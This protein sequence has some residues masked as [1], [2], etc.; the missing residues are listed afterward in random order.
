MDEWEPGPP[1][2]ASRSPSQTGTALESEETLARDGFR[3]DDEW[4]SQK[5][6]GES[7]SFLQVPLGC[8]PSPAGWS[9]PAANGIQT[10]LTLQEASSTGDLRLVDGTS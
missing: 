9:P 4:V 5:D 3:R 10:N 6:T 7:R 1:I 8:L 2:P